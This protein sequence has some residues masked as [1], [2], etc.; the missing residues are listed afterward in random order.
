MKNFTL[1]PV[2][3]TSVTCKLFLMML[4]FVFPVANAG[5]VTVTSSVEKISSSWESD[6]ACV[7]LNSGDVVKLD[8]T[9]K[10][11]NV[12]LSIALTAY[13][14]RKNIRVY[15]NENSTLLGG[16]NTGATVKPHGI[17]YL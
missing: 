2:T 10:K 1:T 15:F 4:L 6:S 9:T 17:L 7:H 11:G 8:M 13:A 3:L 16:C 12:E 14:S 5:Y